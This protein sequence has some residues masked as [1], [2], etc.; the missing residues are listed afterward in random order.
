MF[1]TAE[2][3]KLLAHNSCSREPNSDF[4]YCYNRFGLPCPQALDIMQG[5]CGLP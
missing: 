4:L 3:V 5:T 1:I 2:L